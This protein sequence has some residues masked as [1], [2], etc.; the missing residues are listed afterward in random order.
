ME[1]VFGQQR[2]M[3]DA[4]CMPAHQWWSTYGGGH[5]ELR[6]LAVRV[7]SQVSSACSCERAWSAYDFIHNKR[8][9]RL[10]A[11]RARDLVY[12]FTNGRLVDKLGEGE[13]QFVGWEEEEEMPEL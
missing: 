7:L 4:R 6:K 13:E 3:D 12:V 1:G 8:R 10:S 2:A 11:S 5:P 9:N